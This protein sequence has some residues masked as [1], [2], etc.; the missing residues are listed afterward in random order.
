[1]MIS[2]EIRPSAISRRATTVGLSFSQ[3][4]LG[5]LPPV[6][7]WRARLVASMTS[8]KRLSTFSR[9][10]STVTRAMVLLRNGR[11]VIGDARKYY[12]GPD[13]LRPRPSFWQQCA[14]QPVMQCLLAGQGQA[15]AQQYRLEL[16]Q[17]L[18][19]GIVYLKLVVFH[20][21]T[22][23]R[24]GLRHARGD[25]FLRILT[26][27]AQALQQGFAAGRQ[28]ED[29]ACLGQRPAHLLG[30]LPVDLQDQVMTGSQGLFD[31]GLGR[32]I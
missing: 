10:S 24:G 5:S 8:S 2:S 30:A 13:I 14:Q 26:P 25:H 28:N 7:I 16:I 22:H 18:L 32:T 12:A 4:T 6:A 9:Q 23:F 1:A 20:V 3:A 19:E 11:W 27:V 17:R 21:M 29:G 31:G 15:V